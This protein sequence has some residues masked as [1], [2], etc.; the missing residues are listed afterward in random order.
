MLD[1]TYFTLIDAEVPLEDITTPAG[2]LWAYGVLN[3]CHETPGVTG[4]VWGRHTRDPSVVLLVVGKFRP[5][6]KTLS[7]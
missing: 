3:N 4:V 2:R 5:P 1:I 6:P 7:F